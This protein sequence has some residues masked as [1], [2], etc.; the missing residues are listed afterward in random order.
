MLRVV[1]IQDLAIT[2]GERR[3]FSRLDLTLKAG[4]AA[5]LVGRN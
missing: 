2:R 1:L 4:E 3:L 5:A